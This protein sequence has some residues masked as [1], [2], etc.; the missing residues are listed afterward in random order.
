MGGTG[1]GICHDDEEL[2]DIVT[3]GL[4][5]SPVTQCLLENQLQGI[6]KLNMK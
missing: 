6:R 5:Y 2:E 4:R 1:G 3:N